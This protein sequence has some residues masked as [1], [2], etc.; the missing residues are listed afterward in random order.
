MSL[1]LWMLFAVLYLFPGCVRKKN[2]APRRELA[3]PSV[4]SFSTNPTPQLNSALQI[5]C[6]AQTAPPRATGTVQGS[7]AVQGGVRFPQKFLPLLVP[8][9]LPDTTSSS[10]FSRRPVKKA[11]TS[12]LSAVSTTFTDLCFEDHIAISFLKITPTD[13]V[14]PSPRQLRSKGT[15]LLPRLDATSYTVHISLCCFA[16]LIAVPPFQMY[17]LCDTTEMVY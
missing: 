3:W 1:V 7:R 5:P 15:A 14:R 16:L 8:T 17:C 2:Y 9:S 10:D 11:G 6:A 13:K 12:D 4:F